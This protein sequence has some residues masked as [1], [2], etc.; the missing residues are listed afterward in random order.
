MKTAG[1]SAER[2]AVFPLDN[3]GD[4]PELSG[5]QETKSTKHRRKKPLQKNGEVATDV[6]LSNLQAGVLSDIFFV[7]FGML[8]C[9]PHSHQ[10]HNC[11][12]QT[13]CDFK[14]RELSL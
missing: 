12:D 11:D 8:H 4:I 2:R 14:A 5:F 1:T 9:Q 6:T 3:F 13:H 10:L 7:C